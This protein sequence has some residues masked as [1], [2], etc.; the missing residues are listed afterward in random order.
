MQSLSEGS[1][2]PHK[3]Q[4]I[5]HQLEVSSSTLKE[6]IDTCYDDLLRF[7]RILVYS[8]QRTLTFDEVNGIATEI[9]SD[10]TVEVLAQ[11]RQYNL[12]RQPRPWILGFVRNAVA[13][14]R[15]RLGIETRRGVPLDYFLRDVDHAVFDEM[16]DRLLFDQLVWVAANSDGCPEEALLEKEMENETRD[17]LLSL[18]T[19]MLSLSIED[20]EVLHQ[21]L[22]TNFDCLEMARSLVITPGATRTR[23]HRALKRLG[24]AHFR[25]HPAG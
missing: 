16:Q 14:R 8:S 1:P 9:M 4:S 21:A 23:L 24:E 5:D 19:T 10:V 7:A 15:E 25:Q 13:R 3:P 12:S 6:C 11:S 18:H 22:I 17:Q 20:Q 2:T